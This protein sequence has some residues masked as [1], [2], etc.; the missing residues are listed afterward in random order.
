VPQ[1]RSSALQRRL[2]LAAGEQEIGDSLD[3]GPHRL[4]VAL[5]VIAE[6]RGLNQGGPS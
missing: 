3:E 6:D 5:P 4:H 2:L 1:P